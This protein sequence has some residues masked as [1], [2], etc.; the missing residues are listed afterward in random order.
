MKDNYEEVATAIRVELDEETDK[1]YIVFEV[2]EQKYKQFIKR[3][4]SDD[5]LFKVINKKL[6]IFKDR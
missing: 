2:T 3:H 6:V 1:L 5:I 4:W